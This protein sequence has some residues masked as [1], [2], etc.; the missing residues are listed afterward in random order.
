MNIGNDCLILLFTFPSAAQDP[1]EI[2]VYEYETAPK[3]LLKLETLPTGLHCGATS[4]RRRFWTPIDSSTAGQSDV[5][6]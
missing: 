1:S 4:T 5:C 3:G 6:G 2:R